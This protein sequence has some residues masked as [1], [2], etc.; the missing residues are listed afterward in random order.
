MHIVAMG[1][2]GGW[3]LEEGLYEYNYTVD[4]QLVATWSLND[5]SP[6]S[7]PRLPISHKNLCTNGLHCY[8]REKSEKDVKVKETTRIC[9]NED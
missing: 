6:I 1:I 9:F 5:P 7:L 4:L 2:D 8:Y 3:G